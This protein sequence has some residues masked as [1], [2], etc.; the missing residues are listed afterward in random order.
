MRPAHAGGLDITWARRSLVSRIGYNAA[1]DAAFRA[2]RPSEFRDE[3]PQASVFGVVKAHC[4]VLPPA[5]TMEPMPYAGRVH[6]PGVHGGGDS[7][8]RQYL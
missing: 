1:G 4:W 2:L 7:H 6:R 8:L 5:L 3:W